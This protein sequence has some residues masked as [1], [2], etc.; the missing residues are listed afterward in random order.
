MVAAD[1]LAQELLNNNYAKFWKDIKKLNHK[2]N[3][4]PRSI[5][6]ISGDSNIAVLFKVN[7]CD[8]YDSVS[9]S[10]EDIMSITLNIRQGIKMMVLVI[11]PLTI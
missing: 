8:L 7:Y 11:L 2:T 10:Q 4:L 3:K 1:K 5:N 6:N 9:S